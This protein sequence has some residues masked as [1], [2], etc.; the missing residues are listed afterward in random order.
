[1]KVIVTV[2][3]LDDVEKLKATGLRLESVPQKR[4]GRPPNKRAPKKRV[5]RRKKK[6]EATS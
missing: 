4:I 5:Y 2:N 1:M 6:P 3:S